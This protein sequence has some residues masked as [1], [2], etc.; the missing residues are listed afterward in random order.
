MA[1]LG[2]S[3]NLAK[4]RREVFYRDCG[5]CR[6]CGTLLAFSGKDSRGRRVP[7]PTFHHVLAKADGG[8]DCLDNILTLCGH[9][10][11]IVDGNCRKR[12]R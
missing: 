3:E 11:K 10:H 5:H 6:E 2:T 4:L 9:C 12:R 7:K 1:R 8:S